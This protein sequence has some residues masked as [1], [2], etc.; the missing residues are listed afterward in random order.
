MNVIVYLTSEKLERFKNF[1]PVNVFHKPE[2]YCFQFNIDIREVQLTG[3]DS[4]VLT[5]QRYPVKTVLTEER[6]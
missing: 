4:N 5:I 2:A 6:K 3:K 1:E